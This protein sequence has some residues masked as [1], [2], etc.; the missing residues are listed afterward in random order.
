MPPQPLAVPGP[1]AGST[2]CPHGCV[3]SGSSQPPGSSA[4]GSRPATEGAA[5]APAASGPIPSFIL[6]GIFQPRRL[7]CFCVCV[8][9]VQRPFQCQLRVT[10]SLVDTRSR[11]AGPRWGGWQTCG[12]SPGGHGL[13]CEVTGYCDVADRPRPRILPRAPVT[14]QCLPAIPSHYQHLLADSQPVSGRLLERPSPRPPLRGYRQCVGEKPV[15]KAILGAWYPPGDTPRPALLGCGSER[16]VLA[17]RR[18]PACL[19]ALPGGRRPRRAEGTA[20]G[21]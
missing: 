18:P 21:T 10:G 13:L 5:P 4:P 6:F 16:G 14:W 9:S 17:P 15:G 20:P 1:A 3:T 2:R 12:G 19:S 8:V 7:L 11:Q